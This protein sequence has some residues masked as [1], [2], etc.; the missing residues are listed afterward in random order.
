MGPK[1]TKFDFFMFKDSLLAFSHSLT[2]PSSRLTSD[3]SSFKFVIK[4]KVKIASQ[5]SI[6]ELIKSAIVVKET[7]HSNNL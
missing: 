2:V 6:T 7:Y 4:E 5:S 1:I 3:P